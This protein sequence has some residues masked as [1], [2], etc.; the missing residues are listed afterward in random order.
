MERKRSV[1]IKKLYNRNGNAFANIWKMHHKEDVLFETLYV[2]Q[3]ETLRR[4]FREQRKYQSIITTMRRKIGYMLMCI[5]HR[6]KIP[7]TF[8]FWGIKIFLSVKLII[9]DI[10]LGHYKSFTSL[11]LLSL[12]ET[13]WRKLEKMRGE[14]V[15]QDASL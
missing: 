1:C 7:V 8:L 9:R 14:Q 10:F 12:R 6:F 2:E 3:S 15:T 4:N 11:F 5:W 13:H